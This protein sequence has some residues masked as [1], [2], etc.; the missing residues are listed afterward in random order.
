[1]GS[2]NRKKVVQFVG[3]MILFGVVTVLASYELFM[4]G[5]KV[6]GITDF[7]FHYNRLVGLVNSGNE[8]ILFPKINNTF[9]WGW[10]YP[11]ALF[12]GE[13]PLYIGVIF[14]KVGFGTLTSYKLMCIALTFLTMVIAYASMKFVFKNTRLSAIFAIVY[15]VAT[16]R[17]FDLLVRGAFGEAAAFTFLPVIFAGI[18]AIGFRDKK[19]DWWILGVV[20]SALL[21]THLLTFLM[22]CVVLAFMVVVVYPQKYILKRSNLVKLCKAAGVTIAATLFY[23]LPMM[24]QLHKN[25]M[26][27]NSGMRQLNYFTADLGKL[28]LNSLTN[29]KLG[30]ANIGIVLVVLVVLRVVLARNS[31]VRIADRFT[32]VGLLFMISASGVLPWK[33][34]LTQT[35]L[36]MIQFPFRLLVFATFFLA[37]GAAIYLDEFLKKVSRPKTISALFIVFCIGI[38]F[39]YSNTIQD[40]YGVAN[41]RWNTAVHS[42][43]IGNGREYLRVGTNIN[44]LKRNARKLKFNKAAVKVNDL[45]MTATKLEFKYHNAKNAIV[46]VPRLYYPGY[47]AVSEN[48]TKLK[49]GMNAHGGVRVSHLQQSGSV[50]VKYTGTAIQH[51]SSA[52]SIVSVLGIILWQMFGQFYKKKN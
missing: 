40:A 15:S 38:S 1:M 16:F 46:D 28:V 26:Y 11:P 44:W 10:G 24:E 12:Y 4:P 48:G 9:L 2:I 47:S 23:T 13:L 6:V 27:V 32:S 45:K 49:I 17:M 18:Y 52:L 29:T 37:V 42:D 25:H 43:Q 34:L 14:A 21:L 36:K 3:L 7:Y 30:S 5:Y 22:T 51:V 31:Q 19:C 8:H 35:P 50:I 33:F 39:A 41:L 20:M